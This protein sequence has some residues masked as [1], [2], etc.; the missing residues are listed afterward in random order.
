MRCAALLA[1]LHTAGIEIDRSGIGGKVV[2]V[3]PAVSLARW[4]LAHRCYQRAENAP[5]LDALVTRLRASAPWLN[6]GDYESTC[7]T[8]DDAFDAVIAALSAAAAAAGLTTPP[9][10]SAVDLARGEGRIVVPHEGSVCELLK[11][12]VAVRTE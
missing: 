10:G 11:A 7:R 9:T 8:N 6:L 3:Y 2:E 12:S 1:E 5:H 4:G